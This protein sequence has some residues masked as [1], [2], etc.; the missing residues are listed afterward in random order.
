M[1]LQLN[2]WHIN[3]DTQLAIN[4]DVAVNN[5]SSKTQ[6]NCHKKSQPN[7]SVNGPLRILWSHDR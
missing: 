3:I 7:C 5:S 6:Y 4:A 1:N 2:I